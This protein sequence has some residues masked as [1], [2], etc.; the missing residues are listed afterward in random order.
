VFCTAVLD[1][2]RVTCCPDSSGRVCS[3]AAS[4]RGSASDGGARNCK[5]GA[6]TPGSRGCNRRWGYR[7]CGACV[8]PQSFQQCAHWL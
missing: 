2:W 3:C 5:A 1:R 8:M 6:V 4:E 7:H